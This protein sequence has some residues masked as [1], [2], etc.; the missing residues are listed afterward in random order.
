MK[1]RNEVLELSFNLAVKIVEFSEEL[2]N[3][4]KFVIAR[5]LLRSGTSVGANI[6]EAQSAESKADF[7]H[8]L[9]I[10]HKKAIETEYWLELIKVGT[11]YPSPSTEI[12]ELLTSVQKLLNSIISSSKK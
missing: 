3:L 4:K 6:R 5:Q 9:K 7:I 1:S 12:M 10:A 8:K 2:E 11:S